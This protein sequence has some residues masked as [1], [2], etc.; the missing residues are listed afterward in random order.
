MNEHLFIAVCFVAA[1][2]ALIA[3]IQTH[4]AAYYK[5]R[6]EEHEEIDTDGW[7]D[8]ALFWRR[9]FEELLAHARSNEKPAKSA[10]TNQ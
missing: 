5:G 6:C 2:F 8:E 7:R 1:I 3:Y 10:P 9:N 4:N